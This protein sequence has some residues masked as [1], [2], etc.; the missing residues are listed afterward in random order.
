MCRKTPL[1]I[2]LKIEEPTYTNISQYITLQLEVL[3]DQHLKIEIPV[4]KLN[5][6]NLLPAHPGLLP[7]FLIYVGGLISSLFPS[8]YKFFRAE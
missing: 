2:C 6:V 4:S 3:L 7:Y 1:D 5:M 8:A